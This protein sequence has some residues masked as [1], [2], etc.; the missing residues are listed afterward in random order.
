VKFINQK[1]CRE[2]ALEVAKKYRPAHPFDRVSKE[3]LERID[4]EI[5]A[6][7]VRRVQGL[8]SVGR[9]IK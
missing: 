9:T 2:F 7:I 4:A 3:F 8:P 1:N 5:R 6:V